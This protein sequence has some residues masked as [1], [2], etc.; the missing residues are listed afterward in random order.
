MPTSAWT[1]QTRSMP[2]CKRALDTGLARQPRTDPSGTLPHPPN[3]VRP[4]AHP[5]SHD[6][7]GERP[8]GDARPR[9]S[10]HRRRVARDRGW[11]HVRNV[12]R[13]D[14]RTPMIWPIGRPGQHRAACDYL[15]CGVRGRLRLPLLG[16]PIQHDLGARFD[17]W[18]PGPTTSRSPSRFGGGRAGSRV[19]RARG[20]R[21][22][23]LGRGPCSSR[24]E[25]RSPRAAPTAR[26]STEARG[27]H[28]EPIGRRGRQAGV[29]LRPQRRAQYRMKYTG[30]ATPAARKAATPQ[31]VA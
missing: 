18:E 9:R 15:A 11:R 29:W 23:G 21:Q 24:C 22:R 20:G 25:V 16:L 6:G 30:T 1:M 19:W 26:G 4:S 14:Q 8:H 2:K 13:I 28:G 3:A 12:H 31:A 7:T 10:R 5:P 27:S 17:G